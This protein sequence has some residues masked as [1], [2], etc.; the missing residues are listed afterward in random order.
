MLT[1]DDRNG[2]GLIFGML[3]Q[4]VGYDLVV[5]VTGLMVLFDAR[6]F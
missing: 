1:V 5:P 4:Q 3:G 6:C 2:I